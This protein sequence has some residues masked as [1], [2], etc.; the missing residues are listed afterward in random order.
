MLRAEALVRAERP[1]VIS[2]VGNTTVGSG[3]SR[4]NTPLVGLANRDFIV[5]RQR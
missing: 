5:L 2:A 4:G 3:K 1:S